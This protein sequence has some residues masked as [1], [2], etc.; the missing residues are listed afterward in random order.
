MTAPDPSVVDTVAG[1]AIV[2]ALVVAVWWVT[3]HAADISTAIRHVA[4]VCGFSDTN[5]D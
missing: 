3:D 1:L 2:V 4:A 5:P